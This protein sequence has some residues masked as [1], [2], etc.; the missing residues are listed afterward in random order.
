MSRVLTSFSTQKKSPG[1]I[2][3]G[4]FI[5]CIFLHFLLYADLATVD[6]VAI[7]DK[8][9]EVYTAWNLV[10]RNDFIVVNGA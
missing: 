6:W 4:L 5:T 7:I 9:I 1:K 8:F 3:P 2:H 10:H